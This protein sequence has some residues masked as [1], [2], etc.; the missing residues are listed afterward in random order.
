MRPQLSTHPLSGACLKQI[1]KCVYV[2]SWFRSSRRR[3]G[4]FAWGVA[5]WLIQQITESQT[6]STSNLRK[7]RCHSTRD[8]QC[9]SHSS[10]FKAIINIYLG[11]MITTTLT[12]HF[13]HLFINYWS[14]NN[15]FASFIICPPSRVCMTYI[16]L[17]VCALTKVE[18]ICL[19]VLT[20]LCQDHVDLPKHSF[21]TG[22]KL[23]MVSPWEPL[24]ICPVSV[25]KVSYAETLWK[26][27]LIKQ[28]SPSSIP[29]LPLLMW[30]WILACFCQEGSLCPSGFWIPVTGSSWVFY[31]M[32]LSNADFCFFMSG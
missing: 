18:H 1:Q 27:C 17:H 25:T 4:K 24:Q 14:G 15:V 22:M 31:L 7:K 8:K 29:Q 28:T 11:L 32:C 23:E 16:V 21:K 30:H 20:L 2:S 13:I 9:E 3:T 6:L 5:A 19:K 26:Q 10:H 12:W